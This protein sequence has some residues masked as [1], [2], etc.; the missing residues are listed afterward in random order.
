MTARYPHEVDVEDTDLNMG[1]SYRCLDWLGER[2]FEYHRDFDFNMHGGRE[3]KTTFYFR[4]AV[5]AVEFKML[6]G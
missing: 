3:G 5:L 1:P 6:F 4:D 2:T